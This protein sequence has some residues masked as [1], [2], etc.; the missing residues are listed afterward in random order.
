MRRTTM[1]SMLSV[2]TERPHST[3]ADSNLAFFRGSEDTAQSAAAF[4]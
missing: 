4:C 2:M 3:T 1:R